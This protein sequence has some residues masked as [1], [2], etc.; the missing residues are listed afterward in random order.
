MYLMFQ[1]EKKDSLLKLTRFKM[2]DK[3]T[4]NYGC[5]LNLSH[6]GPEKKEI[7]NYLLSEVGKKW[8]EMWKMETS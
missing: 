2:H 3:V 7:S 4:M 1:L 5:Q 6:K 8:E